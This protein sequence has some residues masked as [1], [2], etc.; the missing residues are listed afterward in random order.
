MAAAA[1]ANADEAAGFPDFDRPPVDEVSCGIR[2]EP[3]VNF[4]IPHVGLFW[5]RFRKDYP[6]IEHVQPIAPDG[7][8]LVDAATGAPLPRVWFVNQA[9]DELVQ[10]QQDHLF[11]NWRK[12]DAEYPRF[13]QL[14]PKFLKAKSLLEELLQELGMPGVVITQHQMTYINILP[15]GEAWGATQDI[16]NV[17]PCCTEM[18]QFNFLGQPQNIAWSSRFLLPRDQGQLNVKLAQGVR[19]TDK[20]PVFVLELQAVGQPVSASWDKSIEWYHL[21]HEWIVKG[22]AAITDR[23]VQKEIWGR[24]DA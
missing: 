2:F 6:V 21:A 12:R 14:F 7:N 19:R 5:E 18:Q 11:Y 10:F 24:Q 9:S 23:R 3:L 4:K 8:L 13:K 15:Q 20:N 22:F 17:I 1:V 16:C